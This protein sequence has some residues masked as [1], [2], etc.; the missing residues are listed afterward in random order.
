MSH[1]HLFPDW[2]LEAYMP[3]D[4]LSDGED[5]AYIKREVMNFRP[6]YAIYDA[7]GQRLAEA[8]TREGAVAMAERADLIPY[9]VN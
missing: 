5:V 7:D 4:F 6:I 8:N 1:K 2:D 9:H 3:D